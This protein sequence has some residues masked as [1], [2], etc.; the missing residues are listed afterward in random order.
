MAEGLSLPMQCY[1]NKYFQRNTCEEEK[2]LNW[3]R[4][5]KN[6]YSRN[7][8]FKEGCGGAAI[9]TVFAVLYKVKVSKKERGHKMAEG[10]IISATTI[11][12]TG[13]Y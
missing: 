8:K 1:A 5:V 3:W 7:T 9:N 13:K 10:L 6:G 2:V 11:T 4:G 12:D